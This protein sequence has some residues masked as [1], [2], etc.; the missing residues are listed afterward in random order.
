MTIQSQDPPRR[1]MPFLYL[2]QITHISPILF[3]TI[4]LLVTH[5]SIWALFFVIVCLFVGA[6]A[7]GYAQLFV[8]AKQILSVY[9]DFCLRFSG[10]KLDENDITNYVDNGS[11]IRARIQELSPGAGYDV[12]DDMKVRIFNVNRNHDPEGETPQQLSAY[13]TSYP[14]ST[15]YLF[16]RGTPKQNIS[17]FQSFQILHELGHA[18]IDSQ[19]LVIAT[20]LGLWPCIWLIFWVLINGHFSFNPF[21]FPTLISLGLYLTIATLLTWFMKTETWVLNEANADHF[22]IRCMPSE[23]WP[24]IEELFKSGYIFDR[25][26]NEKANSTRVG[27]L[28]DTIRR[29][30]VQKPVVSHRISLRL[31]LLYTFLSLSGLTLVWL[32]VI[33]K[34]LTFWGLLLNII[35]LLFV[36]MLLYVLSLKLVMNINMFISDS[37]S[38]MKENGIPKRSKLLDFIRPILLPVLGIRNTNRHLSRCRLN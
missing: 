2:G 18:N 14:I 35:M 17:P 20:S 30:R 1:L 19:F 21:P 29:F 38:Q 32:G 26:V 4:G 5:F 36:P 6:I 33:S 27:L 3:C 7:I 15:A 10:C 16:V 11:W 23:K 9:Y 28:F 37:L 22:A 8:S 13:F 25:K 31:V 34:P 12:E 24:S